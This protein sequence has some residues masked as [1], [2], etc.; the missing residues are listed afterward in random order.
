MLVDFVEQVGVAGFGPVDGREL[1]LGSGWL[2]GSWSFTSSHSGSCGVRVSSGEPHDELWTVEL[3]LMLK[4]SSSSDYIFSF[5][6]QPLFFWIF[7]M[8]QDCNDYAMVFLL[9]WHV[10]RTF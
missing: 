8:V 10:A 3:L 7:P 5:R 2:H 6:S 1:W 4:P 9:L